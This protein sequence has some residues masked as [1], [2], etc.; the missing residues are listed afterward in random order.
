MHGCRFSILIENVAIEAYSV[1][2][3]TLAEPIESKLVFERQRISFHVNRFFAVCAS[4][5]RS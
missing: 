4:T 5:K 2:P 3:L 1:G